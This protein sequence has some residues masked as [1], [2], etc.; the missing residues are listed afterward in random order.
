MSVFASKTTDFLPK[1]SFLPFPIYFF[2]RIYLVNYETMDQ[3]RS[4]LITSA[5]GSVG[6]LGFEK[7]LG[8]K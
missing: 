6:N 1:Q 4:N 2:N 5:F 8:K 3:K 7:L